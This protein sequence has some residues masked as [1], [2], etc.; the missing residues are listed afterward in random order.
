MSKQF[1][2]VIAV[3]V[4]LFVG[5]FALSGSKSDTS[6]KSSGKTLTQ[7]VSGNGK[8]GVTLVEYGDYQ[9]PFCQ[10]YYATVKQVQTDMNDQI[11]FQFRNFPL[12]NNHK[13]AFAAARAAEAA[14]LQNKFWE[15]HDLLYEQNDP[16]GQNGWVAAGDPTPYFNQFAQQ[17]GLNAAQFKKDFAS[18]KVNDLINA[19]MAEGGRLGITGTPTFYLDG[20]QV[21][22]SQLVDSQ[23]RPSVAA[24]EKTINAEI[25]K[26][27]SS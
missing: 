16:N 10:Q 18:V 27:S 9:C 14:A 4:L 15:M 17:I 25:A 23:G 26:K 24:F 20:K 12:V 6:S 19:D 11:H 5:L 1:W 22:A 7:H 13:N 21:N 2:A 8:S 3:I